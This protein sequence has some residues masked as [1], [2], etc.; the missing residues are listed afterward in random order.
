MAAS[1]LT[2]PNLP[3]LFAC[4][5]FQARSARLRL[6]THPEMPFVGLVLGFFFMPSSAVFC[7]TSLP[8]RAAETAGE[9][10]EYEFSTD[11]PERSLCRR[12]RGCS[13]TTVLYETFLLT[14]SIP[15]HPGPPLIFQREVRNSQALKPD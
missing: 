10:A 14:Y 6:I 7:R 1:G 15:T 12:A 5:R 4:P 13:A 2:L 3:L 8:F 9:F 11:P